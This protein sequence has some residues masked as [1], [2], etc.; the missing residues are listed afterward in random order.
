MRAHEH[1]GGSLTF[2]SIE[3]EGSCF[4][5]ATPCRP[6]PAEQER[7]IS[8]DHVHTAH[9]FRGS[10]PGRRARILLVEDVPPSQELARRI[11][12]NAGFHVDV[13]S[14]AAGAVSCAA[15]CRYD[16]IFMDLQ[17]PDFSGFEATQR[18]RADEERLHE[19]PV[20]I[21]AVTGHALASHRDECFRVGM[22]D[23]ASKPLLARGFVDLATRWSD[24]RKT[25][26]IADDSPDARALL[27]R[28]LRPCDLRIVEASCGLDALAQLDRQVIDLVAL[29]MH[30]PGMSGV[31]V[32]SQLRLVERLH[33]VPVLAVTGEDSAE[34]HHALM[35]CGCDS[36][37]VK[38]LNRA[39]FIQAVESALASTRRA[40]VT[41][42]AR[43]ADGHDL[44]DL[45]PG[46]LHSVEQGLH[47]CHS[48]LDRLA[49]MDIQSVAHNIKGTGT[50]F[51]F[52][53]L[54]LWARAMESAAKDMDFG[55]TE[56]ALNAL[57]Q[58]LQR[59]RH[60]AESR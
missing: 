7:D 10:M 26:L 57:D 31:D 53:D 11:L 48:S 47:A 8:P 43:P 39:S 42:D 34:S 44:A 46:Y 20:P 18:I 33:A 9:P 45:V 56:T 52:P 2:T 29:D 27:V 23:Y 30:M 35:A 4:H 15:Q 32:V 51:G 55:R 38:P 16:V 24:T 1:L 28:F 3:G 36:V 13:A 6:V 60:L 54:T 12:S 25:V 50:S 41:R 22:T 19:A 17:L 5:L 40:P 37:L 59:A 49:F 14:T 21:V 58:A